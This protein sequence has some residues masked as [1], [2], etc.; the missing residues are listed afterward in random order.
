METDMST[1][2]SISASFPASNVI[3]SKKSDRNQLV[4][5]ALFC[6]IG[7]LASLVAILSGVPAVLY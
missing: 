6:G 7:L 4:G 2:H 1:D 5:I 3:V